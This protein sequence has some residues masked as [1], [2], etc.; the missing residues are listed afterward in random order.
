VPLSVKQ[1]EGW[2]ST[3][4]GVLTP[5]YGEFARLQREQVRAADVIYC[6]TPSMEPLFDA[7]ILTNHEGRKKGRLIVAVGSYTPDMHEL[8]GELLLQATKQYDANHRHYHK[9]APEGGVI[10]VD[11]LDGALKE[12]GEIISAGIQPSQ[13]IE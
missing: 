2:E 8:P 10:V 7:A 1:R 4:F 9:H 6:C 13:L 5:G 12:A 3:T 11:T